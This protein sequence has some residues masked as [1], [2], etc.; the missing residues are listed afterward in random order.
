MHNYSDFTIKYTV[1]MLLENT[2]IPLLKNSLQL[3]NK[4][5]KTISLFNNLSFDNFEH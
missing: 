4:E 1:S 3:F 2:T 5:K